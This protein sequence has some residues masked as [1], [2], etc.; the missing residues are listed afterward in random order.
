MNTSSNGYVMGFAVGVCVVISTM[1]ALTANALKPAQ[2]AAKEL[3]RQKNMLIAAGFVAPDELKSAAELRQIFEQ[4]VREAVVDTV[5][6]RVVE[7]KT[8]KDLAELNKKAVADAKASGGDLKV[9]A[10]RYRAFAVGAGADGKPDT[11]ILPISGKGLWSTIKGYMALEGDFNHVRGVTFYEHGETPGLGGECENPA[12]CAQ[13][14]GKTILDEQGHLVAVGVKKGKVDPAV[15]AE[16]A[17]KVDGL[18]GSTLTSN[19]IT[20]FVKSDLDAF[21]K[22]L[23]SLRT[24]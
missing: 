15:A 16:K 23:T 1:L 11:Y 3:D 2:E 10:A 12:W 19:G 24:K 13:W 7:G 14:K 6:G 8:A 17:H 18:S 22:Y 5:D 20:R 9:A 21:A 4:R